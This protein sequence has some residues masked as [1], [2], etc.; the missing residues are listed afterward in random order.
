MPNK[1]GMTITKEKAKRAGNKNKINVVLCLPCLVLIS[2][3]P[4]DFV[5][6]NMVSPL[7]AVQILMK[8]GASGIIDLSINHLPYYIALK[9]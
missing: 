5:P 7:V 6:L 8:K 2:N 9:N 3:I 1:N 4:S